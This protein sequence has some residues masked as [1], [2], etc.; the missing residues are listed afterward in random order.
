MNPQATEAIFQALYSLLSQAFMLTNGAPIRNELPSVTTG[1]KCPQV[2]SVGAALQPAMY[3][4]EGG[5][6]IA[7]RRGLNLPRYQFE[8]AAIIFFRN[9]QG[10]PGIPSTQMNDLWDAI[11]FQLTQRTLASDGVT[12]VPLL[13]GQHQTLGGVVH[14]AFVEGTAIRN[15]GLQNNQGAIA[16]PITIL[17]G[18]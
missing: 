9:M 14:D 15:E 6:R 5:V 17:K 7:P 2:S 10:D 3:I 8:A 12:V 16:Y 4:M 11:D 1:R 13:G 18:M